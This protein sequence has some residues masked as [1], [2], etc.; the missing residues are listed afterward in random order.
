MDFV[1][2]LF[3]VLGAIVLF[4]ADLI[5]AIMSFKS[6]GDRKTKTGRYT[7]SWSSMNV[8][9]K[10]MLVGLLVVMTVFVYWLSTDSILAP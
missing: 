1:E 10:G 7:P 8:V 5:V 6:L 3:I 9:Q 4:G 2:V